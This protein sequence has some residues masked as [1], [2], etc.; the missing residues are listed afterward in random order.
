MSPSV[1]VLTFTAVNVALEH[2]STG[3]WMGLWCIH[4][5]GEEIGIIMI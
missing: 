4:V 3:E 1:E 5:Y 2:S